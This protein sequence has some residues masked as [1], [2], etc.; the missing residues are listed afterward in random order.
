M[1]LESAYG[2]PLAVHIWVQPDSKYVTSLTLNILT[3][4]EEI[5]ILHLSFR[6]NGKIDEAPNK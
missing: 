6:N 3:Y 5:K 1:R 2:R 4:S